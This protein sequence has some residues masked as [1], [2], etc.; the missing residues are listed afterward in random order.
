MNDFLNQ[1][2]AT[3]HLPSICSTATENPLTCDRT[4]I[5]TNNLEE[6]HRA[7][8]EACL[9]EMSPKELDR[10]LELLDHI[11]DTGIKDKMIEILG[12]DVYEKCGAQ[13]YSLKYYENALYTRQ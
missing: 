8:K 7:L 9:K 4:M 1:L 11:S 3:L 6:I 5:S 13:L 10:M 2:D 12:E